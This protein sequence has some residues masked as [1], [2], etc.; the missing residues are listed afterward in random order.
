MLNIGA[1]LGAMAAS[2]QLLVGGSLLPYVAGFAV[3]TVGLEVYVRY[4]R[5][6]P[7]LRWLTLSLFAYVACVFAA[8]VPWRDL[9]WGVLVPR[10]TWSSEYLT[11][12]V[13][14]LGTTISPYLF[15]WQ[16]GQEVEDE[17]ETP[18]ARPL[19]RTPSQASSEARRIRL[20]TY[21]GM[22][23]SNLIALCIVATTAAT[24]HA[25]GVTDIQTSA[26]AAEALRPI[27]GPFAFYVFA[28]GIIG[29]GLLALP[30]LAGSAAYAV[31]EAAGWHVGLARRPGRARAFY[32]TIGAATVAGALLNLTAIDPVRA[33]FWSAVVNGVVSAPI[34]AMMVV[35]A[36][37][38]DVMGAFT[39]GPSL[40]VVGWVAT[41]AMAAASIAMLT[42]LGR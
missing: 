16:A 38:R 20:D 9:A 24:L 36:C 26:Q 37:R 28:A 32:G 31:G 40:R 17:K 33:L 4:S 29:T 10:V 13:A 5:Y 41:A 34:M 2:L 8:G 42:V 14:I 25:H 35:M 21:V 30:V 19:I 39:L 15:F 23:F 7:V 12:L 3:L 1:D 27:A 22:G 18:G 6:V 11:T